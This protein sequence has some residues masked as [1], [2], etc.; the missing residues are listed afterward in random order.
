MTQETEQY[1]LLG[2]LRFF[3][4]VGLFIVVVVISF[5]VGGCSLNSTGTD[6]LNQPGWEAQHA[7]F[8]GNQLYAV[9]FAGDQTGWIVG[10]EGAILY[11][12]D[13]G[14]SWNYQNS[15]T[16]N[17]LRGMVAFDSDTAWIVGL[18]SSVLRTTNGGQVWMPC[19]IGVPE[20]NYYSI[21]NIDANNVWAV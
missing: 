12:D 2:G 7:Q 16:I 17:A 20:H 19:F 13:A 9:A 10:G 4:T 3:R 21:T 14:A 1:T 18:R 5:L 6:G 11:S 8:E 15:G